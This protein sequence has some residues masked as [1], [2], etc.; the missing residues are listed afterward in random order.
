[1]VRSLMPA[2]SN[3]AG[4]MLVVLGALVMAV[5][6]HLLTPAEGVEDSRQMAEQSP[7]TPQ[8]SKTTTNLSSAV[9]NAVLRGRA[10]LLDTADI[11]VL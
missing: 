5:S 9:E 3:D 6:L 7:P 2:L 1:M 8:T 11:L 10:Q 4:P